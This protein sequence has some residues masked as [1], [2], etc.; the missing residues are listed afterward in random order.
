MK[1]RVGVELC[2]PSFPVKTHRSGQHD[3]DQEVLPVCKLLFTE[4]S[5]TNAL[6]CLGVRTQS[7]LKEGSEPPRVG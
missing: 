3:E 2:P 1:R 7:K 5:P 4:E 6:G